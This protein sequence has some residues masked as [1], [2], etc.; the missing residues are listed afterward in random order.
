[1]EKLSC[2]IPSSRGAPCSGEHFNP[3]WHEIH[4][5]NIEIRFLPLRNQLHYMDELVYGA[6]IVPE[7][8][9]CGTH[10]YHCS[11]SVKLH[12][13]IQIFQFRSDCKQNQNLCSKETPSVE[14]GA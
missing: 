10:S 13:I 5:K 1:L 9:A 4:L 14:V 2:V 11:L 6:C 12:L 3:F 7:F 8:K